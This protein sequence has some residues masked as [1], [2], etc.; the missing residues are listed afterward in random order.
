ME[1]SEL[2]E[3]YLIAA[4]K[5]LCRIHELNVRVKKL[6]GN[7]KILMKRR[8]YLLYQDAADCRHCATLLINYRNG[9][10]NNEQNN[11]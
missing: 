4:E 9:G 8:I 2:G 7:D 5:L 10:N 1:L 6:S 3:Q 11:L